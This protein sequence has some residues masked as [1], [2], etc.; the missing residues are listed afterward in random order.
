LDCAKCD[1]MRSGTACGSAGAVGGK[2]YADEL[3]TAIFLVCD[4]D[5]GNERT[6]NVCG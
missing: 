6:G 5:G 2:F 4:C 3:P 1:S